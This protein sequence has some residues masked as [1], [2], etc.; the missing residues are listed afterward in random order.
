MRVDRT[1]LEI[2]KSLQK[3]KRILNKNFKPWWHTMIKK[4]TATALSSNPK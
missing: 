4:L 3:K 1:N 2:G